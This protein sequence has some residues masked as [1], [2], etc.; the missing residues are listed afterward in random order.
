V[1]ILLPPRDFIEELEI[2]TLS[3]SSLSSIP[4]PGLETVGERKSSP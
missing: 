1:G 2:P 3:S 4:D